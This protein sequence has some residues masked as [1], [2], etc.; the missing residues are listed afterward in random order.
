MLESFIQRH[1]WVVDALAIIFILW[2]AHKL[3]DLSP[4]AG[5]KIIVEE[6]KELAK[7]RPTPGSLNLS[8]VC[9]VA[10]VG[11]LVVLLKYAIHLEE[12]FR[13]FLPRETAETVQNSIGLDIVIY[14][15][16]GVVVASL[17]AVI[18]GRRN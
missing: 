7:L 17:L 2:A 3:F 13:S 16:A 14:V 12:F 5:F 15:T 6:Y 4:S 18:V 11:V 1:D 10:A 9:V 8:C